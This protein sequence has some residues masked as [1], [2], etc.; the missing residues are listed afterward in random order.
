V[1]SP[2]RGAARVA[3]TK[4]QPPPARLDLLART[5]LVGALATGEPR[6]LTLVAAPVGAG[7]TSVLLAWSTAPAERRAFAWVTLDEDDDDPVRFWTCVLQALGRVRPGVA[8]RVASLIGPPGPGVGD[9]VVQALVAELA[10]RDP[11]VVLVLDDYHL[12]SAPEVHDAVR[13]LIEQA[14]SALHVAIAS[15]A[16]PPLPVA[17]L[18]M[19]QE[20][21]EVRA[22]DLRFTVQE[23]GELLN[24]VLGL[25]V[26]D[27]DVARLAERTEGWAAGLQ[28]AAASLRRRPDPAAFVDGFAGDDR[29]VVDYLAYEVL[30]RLPGERRDFLLRTSVLDR[31]SGP[32]CDAL[33]G[34]T[35]SDA[36]LRDLERENLFLVALDHKRRWYRYHHLFAGLLRDALRRADPDLSDVLHRRAAAWHREHGLVS[37][38]VRHATAAGDVATARTLITLHWYDLLQQGRL[39]TVQA[40]VDGLGSDVV[41]GD[42]DLCLIKAWAAIN[43]GRL[44]ELDR[45]IGAAQRAGGGV[46]AQDGAPPVEAGVA[47]LR[48]IHR[49]MEGDVGRAVRAGRHAIELEGGR[50]G[51]PWRPVGCPVLGLA[52]FWRRETEAARETLEAAVQEARAGG[53]HLA[54]MHAGG[55]LA[56]IALAEGDPATA[57]LRAA[58]ALRLARERGLDEHWAGA[59][60]HLSHGELLAR[61]GGPDEALGALRRGVELA[62]RG[63][64]SVETGYALTLLA[65][66]LRQA[67]EE[68]RAR[69][70]DAQARAVVDRCADP[71]RLADVLAAR[72]APPAPA[73]AR[74]R[75][76]GAATAAARPSAGNGR[77]E[78]TPSEIAV[79]RLL[80]SPLNQ[81]QISDELFLSINTVKSHTK[82]IYR[83]LAAGSRIEAV[84]LARRRGLIR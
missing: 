12:I 38:A 46:P 67:G 63:M 24:G 37:D 6:R 84:A 29:H 31:L 33:L 62:R 48:A 74:A 3:A 60:A 40:W 75:R 44:D 69:A 36:V 53:N 73:P 65:G 20:L 56:A 2:Q 77:D 79:L 21:T 41:L 4:L 13:A 83:K 50:E 9:E 45:W 80:P 78:L 22:E 34:A 5:R 26:A 14:P 70:L 61:S 47:S 19:R 58:G 82:A 72:G 55:G 10:E 18:R 39:A 15:R 7:K 8:A 16:D 76:P 25:G 49:Y 51:S 27:A 32:L 64:A 28:L 81:R 30:D 68:P 54:E 71:G 35:E 66:A 43:T 57:E 17:R 11:G 52:L 1:G 59:L 23:A 42:A